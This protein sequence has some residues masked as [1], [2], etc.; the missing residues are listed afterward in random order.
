M[1]ATMPKPK[2]F[3]H[4]VIP[5]TQTPTQTE[6]QALA[7]AALKPS[8]NS[9]LV[10]D[11][12]QRNVMGADVEVKELIRGLSDSMNKVKDGDL[13]GLESMLV[14]QAM[15]LQTMFTSLA[16]RAAGQQQLR[17]YESFM[18]MALK[19]QAQ[20]RATIQAVI[21]LKFPRQATFVKQANI[22]HG[23]QQVNNGISGE[24][25]ARAHAG[26]ISNTQNK[27][28]EVD[29]GQFSGGMD[30]RAAQ[31]AKRSDPALAA[32]GAVHRAKKRGG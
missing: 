8:L 24:T 28:L 27:Q 17:H 6:A 15:A 18:G 25:N 3:S 22:A 21:D 1:S 16:R 13:S 29:H 20:S 9:S 12:Y 14:G 10:I 30:T 23:P 7:V 19:A 4:K 2:P 26:E 32:V 11:A 31:A 5:V